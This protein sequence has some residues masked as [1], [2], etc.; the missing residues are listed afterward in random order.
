[1]KKMLCVLF[2]GGA[3]IALLVFNGDKWGTNQKKIV[4]LMVWH[5]YVEQM[6]DGFHVLIQEFN[7]TV[8]A[9]EGITVSV[10]AEANESSLNE[11]LMAAVKRDPG[12]P[13]RPDMAVIYPR[14]AVELARLGALAD[15]KTLFAK[16]ELD[17][18]VPRF[19]EEGMLG[20][21]TPFII[22]IAKSTEV[23]FVNRTLFD[24]FASDAGIDISQ[25]ATFEGILDAA[26]KYYEWTDAKT[27]DIPD[28]GKT[29]YYPDIPFNYA[30][31][32]FEQLGQSFVEDGGLNF[33]SPA[34]RRIWDSYFPHAVR[35]HVAIFDK[36]AG[37]LTM[38]GDIV[39]ASS[40]SAG[41][42]FQPTTV[43]YADNTKEDV[44]FDVLPYPVFEGG[45]RVVVQRGGGMCILKSDAEKERAAALFIKWLTAPAQNLRF[46]AFTGY[47]PV[48]KEALD[49]LIIDKLEDI[50]NEY[51]RKSLKTIVAMSK[52]YRFYVTPVFS[53]F[54]ELQKKYVTKL[55][56]TTR[57]ARREY[58]KLH[59]TTLQEEFNFEAEMQSFIKNF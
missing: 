43:R 24:R 53:G 25:L 34:F 40:T 54:D 22:P 58:K 55:I 14:I 15:L 8:G 59:E 38:T 4:T 33:D 11:M 42:I 41:A 57:G 10:A 20:G 32:G 5:T 6:S 44:T 45:E 3:I 29:F 46:S 49:L 35:G 37:Y 30:M 13:D 23:L 48:T 26:E 51:V 56:T 28:D 12:A 2:L 1:M 31:I 19:L 50:E 52:D 39:C 17:R 16:N 27:P 21:D 36:Y 7:D 9:K 18:Y 47:M